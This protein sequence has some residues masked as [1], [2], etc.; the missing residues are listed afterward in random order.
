[1]KPNPI[2]DYLFKR[3]E[4]G[5]WRLTFLPANR[6]YEY[7]FIIPVYNE[8]LYLHKTLESLNRLSRDK[9]Q[10]SA[11][12]VVVNNGPDGDETVVSD[13]LKVLEFLRTLEASYTLAWVDASSAGKTLPKK[14]AGVG[15]ARKIGMDF[16]LPFADEDSL[17]CCLDAD[18]LVHPEYLDKVSTFFEETHCSAAVVNFAHQQPDDPQLEEHIR[19]Y[20]QFLKFT[21]DKMEWAGSPYA[22]PAIGSTIVCTARA[23]TAVGG[24]PRKKAGEDFYFLQELAKYRRV[25]RIND[26]LVYPSA[27][28]SDRVHLGTGIRLKQA[29]DG[30]DLNDLN[31]S[32]LAFDILMKWLETGSDGKDTEVQAI[33]EKAGQIHTNLPELLEKESI[34]RVWYGLQ[35]S[36]VTDQQ[37]SDQFHRWFDGL[38]TMRLLKTFSD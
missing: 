28:L 34:K 36:S 7:F 30:F 8:S 12:I 32:E 2:L 9:L 31:Y 6:R 29:Q 18:T 15:L 23:Y 3:A 13:N 26:I 38:K 4:N 21:A 10:K 25:H 33:L 5:P 16:C 24:M 37:F 19:A 35:K 1:M 11:V 14:Q 27:R 20:E 17:L 22:Y